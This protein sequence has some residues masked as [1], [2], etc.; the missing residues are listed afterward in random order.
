[1]LN[2]IARGIG[3]IRTGLEMEIITAGMVHDS[4]DRLTGGTFGR[5]GCCGR[6]ISTATLAAN[7]TACLCAKCRS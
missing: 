2:K 1:M 5:C 7:P 3:S 6:S 4:L